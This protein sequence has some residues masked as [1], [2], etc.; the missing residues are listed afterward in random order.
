MVKDGKGT[1]LKLS[2]NIRIINVEGHEILSLR[3]NLTLPRSK[4]FQ[5]TDVDQTTFELSLTNPPTVHEDKFNPQPLENEDELEVL[6]KYTK[7]HA[8]LP[9]P[10]HRYPMSARKGKNVF[11]KPE[12]LTSKQIRHH[13]GMP[14]LEFWRLVESLSKTDLEEHINLPLPSTILLYR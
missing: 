7:T 9:Y 1:K 5:I 2:K 11:M 6:K 14:E 4:M 3:S 12:M 13:S 8:G 10:I